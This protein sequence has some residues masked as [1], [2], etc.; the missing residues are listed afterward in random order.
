MHAFTLSTQE[1]YVNHIYI[2]KGFNFVKSF[3]STP[4]NGGMKVLSKCQV[5][6]YDS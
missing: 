5:F 6:S 4:L 2:K 1:I 3:H